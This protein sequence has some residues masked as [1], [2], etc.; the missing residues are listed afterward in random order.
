MFNYKYQDVFRNGVL[1]FQREYV[2]KKQVRDVRT[3]QPLREV[4]SAQESFDKDRREDRL[5]S[6][7]RTGPLS[8]TEAKYRNKL[9][10]E[11]DLRLQQSSI[12]LDTKLMCLLRQP[13]P[14]HRD[15]KMQSFVLFYW[16]VKPT[17]KLLCYFI[18]YKQKK[19]TFYGPFFV[20]WPIL[21]T[22][23]QELGSMKYFSLEKDSRDQK[24]WK[25]L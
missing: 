2:G 14:S 12:I 19:P 21:P 11:A 5:L 17:V 9:K 6:P 16:L 1:H 24:V 18:C 13:H 15:I 10:A 7:P 23:K 22:Q 8:M 4:L 25:T 3:L 20:T